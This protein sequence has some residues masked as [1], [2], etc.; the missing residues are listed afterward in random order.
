MVFVGAISDNKAEEGE[1]P[2]LLRFIEENKDLK[3]FLR[4][5]DTAFRVDSVSSFI[6]GLDRSA[7]GAEK[8]WDDDNTIA[9]A[10]TAC[11]ACTDYTGYY[12][13]NTFR[14]EA[15]GGTYDSRETHGT[16]G[17][18]GTYAT[19]GTYGTTNDIV[20][21]E[22]DRRDGAEESNGLSDD[23]ESTVVAANHLAKKTEEEP[24]AEIPTILPISVML[25]SKEESTIVAANHLTKKTEVEPS[26]ISI[27]VPFAVEFDSK[28]QSIPWKDYSNPA[29][30]LTPPPAIE[31]TEEDYYTTSSAQTTEN[32]NRTS[33]VSKKVKNIFSSGLRKSS[34][35]SI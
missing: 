1:A 24:S 19:N 21:S 7:C 29:P 28:E 2:L 13:A 6:C 22:V 32:R 17:T 8:C 10:Y 12:T 26:E 34:Q 5:V 33:I 11:T 16:Y 9:S 15:S 20:E 3:S 14:T 4:K 30:L 27:G 35:A 18:Y 25:D 23:D 31:M